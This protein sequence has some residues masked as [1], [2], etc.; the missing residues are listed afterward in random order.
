MTWIKTNFLWM[1][2]RCN[3][4]QKGKKSVL[5]I[6]LKR[7]AFENL[8]SMAVA[9]SADHNKEEEWNKQIAQQKTEKDTPTVRLQW[10]PGNC[11]FAQQESIAR[12]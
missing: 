5:A 1:M 11:F 3:W 7:D 4:A 6:W 2:Y 10:D 8:L 9:S 12:P